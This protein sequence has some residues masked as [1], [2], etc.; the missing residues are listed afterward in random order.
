MSEVT[1]EQA[2]AAEGVASADFFS[3]ADAKEAACYVFSVAIGRK[4]NHHDLNA[5]CLSV[6][7]NHVRYPNAK[8]SDGYTIRITLK[9]SVVQ[10]T[11]WACVPREV[12]LAWDSLLQCVEKL[13]EAARRWEGATA[14]RKSLEPPQDG[15]W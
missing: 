13:E 10:T 8:P 15:Y 12:K 14:L 4:E 1:Y 9:M 7:N 3:A 2:R 6:Y 5:A 11:R